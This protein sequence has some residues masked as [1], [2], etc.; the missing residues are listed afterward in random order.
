MNK[1]NMDILQLQVFYNLFLQVKLKISVD[2]FLN[3]SVPL[4]RRG[5]VKATGAESAK[6]LAEVATISK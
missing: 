3:S 6:V 2:I 4:S 5:S 1:N